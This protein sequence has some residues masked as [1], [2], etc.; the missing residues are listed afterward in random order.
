M[1]YPRPG[2]ERGAE[3]FAW[4]DSRHTFSFGHYHDPAHMGFSALRVINEDVVNPGAGFDRH[5]HRDMEIVSYILEGSIEHAD[6]T[7]NRF[8]VPAGEVQ[9]MSAGSGIEHSEFNASQSQP[10]KFLQIWIQP[11][12]LGTEPGYQQ[13]LIP[14]NGAL[15]PLITPD[16]RNNSLAIKQDASIYRVQLAEDEELSLEVGDRAAYLHVVQGKVSINDSELVAGDGLGVSDLPTLK[17]Q[18][19]SN[20]FEALWF[21]LPASR[22][23]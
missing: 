15:T 14:Q 13:A 10:L 19:K 7:G 1:I 22:L 5:G 4:L 2:A 9:V 6:S 18:S 16:G 3:K 21:D 23:N 11:N 20:D 8:I 17:V 12:Q